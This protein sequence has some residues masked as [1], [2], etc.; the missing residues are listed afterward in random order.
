MTD[1]D[2][3]AFP[4]DLQ[5]DAAACTFD[6][7]TVIDAVVGLRAEVP[8]DAFTAPSLGTDRRGSGIVLDRA[9]TV[10]TIGYLITEAQ[11]VWLT[12]NRGHVAPAYPLA[13]DQASGF[14]L[15]RALGAL[16]VEP[17]AR[18][19]SRALAVDDEVLVVGH[20]GR[21]HTL[22]A[23]L[24][25]RREFAGYWEYLLDDA[26]F[27]SPAHPHW[28]GAA[29]V[30]GGGRLVG[31]GSLLVQ[32][33]MRGERS[34]GNMFVPIDLLE[35]IYDDLLTRG[36]RRSEPRPWLGLFGADGEEGPVIAAVIEGGPASRAGLRQG[37]VVRLA[38]GERVESLAGFFRAVWR[39]GPAGIAVPLEIDRDGRALQ[40]RVESL[41]R[42]TLLKRPSLH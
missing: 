34:Q 3:W 38:G 21:A 2:P 26:L 7:P 33:E 37:D 13:Y 6:L 40:V 35:P 8:E 14:G 10:L 36:A 32:E 15:V 17:I 24:S 42:Q 20:G 23:S 27:T 31:V 1:P 28:S 30:D 39:L 18:G 11:S 9:G 5:P 12:S 29:L 16:G 41:D 19:R 22:K 4:E 25:G